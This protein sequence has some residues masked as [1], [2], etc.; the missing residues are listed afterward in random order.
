[1]RLSKEKMRNNALWNIGLVNLSRDG[2]VSCALQFVIKPADDL[3]G[4][5]T[6]IPIKSA[7]AAA[8]RKLLFDIVFSSFSVDRKQNTEAG[9]LALL[10]C[11]H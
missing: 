4:L 10:R 6:E 11:C 5:G 3:V 8:S 1:M 7:T 2:D 9:Q